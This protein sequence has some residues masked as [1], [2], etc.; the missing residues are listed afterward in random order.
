MGKWLSDPT[1]SVGFVALM[2]NSKL[3]PQLVLYPVRSEWCPQGEAEREKANQWGTNKVGHDGN[4]LSSQAIHDSVV[5]SLAH[6]FRESVR[7]P[8]MY[9]D[10]HVLPKESFLPAIAYAVMLEARSPYVLLCKAHQKY[11]RMIAH[12]G[13]SREE[14]EEFF[15]K[16]ATRY[17][18]DHLS[19]EHGGNDYI[20]CCMLY[21]SEAIEYDDEDA[22]DDRYGEEYSSILI[23]R[24]TEGRAERE[25]KS[26][27][28]TLQAL[29]S[30]NVNI[31]DALA[32]LINQAVRG[33]IDAEVLSHA[34]MM[35]LDAAL[36]TIDVTEPDMP[37]I[38][39]FSKGAWRMIDTHVEQNRP[40]RLF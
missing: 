24:E 12:K 28:D 27:H 10:T 35:E 15:D 22:Y 9:E 8:W 14:A 26:T 37:V 2:E 4:Q 32:S 39:T 29:P 40:K 30:R 19:K 18:L 1:G 21:D 17:T 13:G 16:L 7:H 38:Y 34:L 3:D 31:A 5:F 23:T 36:I 33:S 6:W 11:Y 20:G 25:L